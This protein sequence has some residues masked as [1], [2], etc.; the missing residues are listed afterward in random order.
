MDKR[1]LHRKVYKKYVEK[2]LTIIVVAYI[3]NSDIYINFKGESI[4]EY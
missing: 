4:N 1:I 3:I 2:W